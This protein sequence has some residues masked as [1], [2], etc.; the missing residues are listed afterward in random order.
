MSSSRFSRSS[1]G[2][3]NRSRENRLWWAIHTLPTVRKLVT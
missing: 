2:S 1:V 3:M